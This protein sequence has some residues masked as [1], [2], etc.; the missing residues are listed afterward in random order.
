MMA[1]DEFSWLAEP[2]PKLKVHGYSGMLEGAAEF[3]APAPFGWH[4]PGS[5]EAAAHPELVCPGLAGF[6]LLSYK[7]SMSQYQQHRQQWFAG[8]DEPVL[9]DIIKVLT[10]SDTRHIIN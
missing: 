5:Q 10:S 7:C 6:I 4:S 8:T 9:Q 1:R 3:G 2:L